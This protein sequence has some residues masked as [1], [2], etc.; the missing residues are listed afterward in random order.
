MKTL[1]LALIVVSV[2]S[3]DQLPDLERDANNTI[4]LYSANSVQLDYRLNYAGMGGQI[5]NSVWTNFWQSPDCLILHGSFMNG[6][7]MGKLTAL[8]NQLDIR[9][10]SG[11]LFGDRPTQPLK[12]R[13]I[14]NTHVFF[15]NDLSTYVT[16][17][18]VASKDGRTIEKLLQEQFG[19]DHHNLTLTYSRACVLIRR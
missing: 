4:P 6:A 17:I 14:N 3:A 2:A 11:I 15:V 18:R 13:V 12:H 1:F 19:S 9:D 16:G 8:V 5:S 10:G 7:P